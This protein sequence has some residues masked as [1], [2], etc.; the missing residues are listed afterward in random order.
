MTLE[1]F[2]LHSKENRQKFTNLFVELS[3]KLL[4]FLN[5]LP[6]CIALES[7]EIESTGFDHFSVLAWQA[8]GYAML[9]CRNLKKLRLSVSTAHYNLRMNSYG[10]IFNGL[11]SLDADQWQAFCQ[12]VSIPSLVEL[13]LSRNRL[14][15]LDSDKWRTLGN[16]LSQN[17]PLLSTLHLNQNSL[18][19]LTVR[20]IEELE[21]LF[22]QSLALVTL[23]LGID[24]Q[25]GI[26]NEIT[27]QQR[28][29]WAKALSRCS[30]LNTLEDTL[31]LYL[32]WP[33]SGAIGSI[34]ELNF[35]YSHM[36]SYKNLSACAGL[37][38]LG[39]IGQRL[40]QYNPE[41]WQ[42][43]GQTL[44][45]CYTLVSL[46][47]ENNDLGNASLEKFSSFFKAIA[48]TPN[49]TELNLSNNKL[50]NLTAEHWS[51]AG[52]EFMQLTSLLKLDI[53]KT[54]LSSLKGKQWRA[55]VPAIT[56]CQRLQELNLENINLS[57]LSAKHW[58]YLEQLFL[59]CAALVT[60][61]LNLGNRLNEL[62][63][64]PV[65]S[66]FLLQVEL[67]PWN[68]FLQALSR[69]QS[70]LRV[71]YSDGGVRDKKCVAS[72]LLVHRKV[73]IENI[74]QNNQKEEFSS[75]A[76]A[77]SVIISEPVNE[78]AE[79]ILIDRRKEKM[80][81]QAVA[82]QL[83]KAVALAARNDIECMSI[84]FDFISDKKN[85]PS[86]RQ[87]AA[88]S[89]VDF[90]LYLSELD[91]KKNVESKSVIKILLTLSGDEDNEIKFLAIET[92]CR[93]V[94]CYSGFDQ[95]HVLKNL[96]CIQGLIL[97]LKH[98]DAR[99]RKNTASLLGF[100]I[101][102]GLENYVAFY[103]AGG[104]PVLVALLK[105]ENSD[106]RRDV[107]N[108]LQ[109]IYEAT[110]Q[111][112]VHSSGAVPILLELL[113]AEYHHEVALVADKKGC[114]TTC[115]VNNRYNENDAFVFAMAL[116]RCCL[117]CSNGTRQQIA[118]I[119]IREGALPIF[120]SLLERRKTITISRSVDET[121]ITDLNRLITILEDFTKSQ[122][123]MITQR[124]S[125]LSEIRN[126]INFLFKQGYRFAA[127]RK[128]P[129]ECV[130]SV[131]TLPFFVN[132]NAKFSEAKRKLES[133]RSSDIKIISD[134]GKDCCLIKGNSTNV[135]KFYEDLALFNQGDQ[136]ELCR[137]S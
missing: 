45:K 12:A 132:Q 1:E 6:E 108:D 78:L 3:D 102:G 93:I 33:L 129:E 103:E 52:N 125:R 131:S 118:E 13:N 70:L 63:E 121:Q 30:K 37:K 53:S 72:S 104:I 50:E 27:I 111:E 61:Y 80:N 66:C 109:Y 65:S 126:D 14:N 69:S 26:N 101:R 91:R 47:F 105:D 5:L 75:S 114:S 85:L 38:A 2:L 116:T 67:S 49:L 24:A 10:F 130:V 76:I 43:F 133:L 56:Q 112:A 68:R 28:E 81:Q 55:F 54:H 134:V 4:E 36:V 48:L 16:V 88:K 110:A 17:C 96:N 19:K 71:V 136:P 113:K 20:Q 39:L 31:F 22:S 137:I 34:S 83:Y 100:F 41:N 119:I 87:L 123:Q 115:S 77:S 11:S 29:A 46:S 35:N 98:S 86:Y 94:V 64:A 90:L 57:L 60:L 92:I 18:E 107:S 44:L 95:C 106:I 32:I 51:I 97:L 9:Q 58:G 117:L 135:D 89:L 42:A 23:S 99:I 40:L 124:T 128:S 73:Q 127:E 25:Y 15:C 84:L 79:R 21:A 59:Q 7:L 74:L 62:S 8:F 120:I 82:V 122:K